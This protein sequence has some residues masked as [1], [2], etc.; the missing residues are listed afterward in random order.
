MELC[1]QQSVHASDANSDHIMR[2]II[3]AEKVTAWIV[4]LHQWS[5]SFILS[6]NTHALIL[7]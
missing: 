4:Y 2:D 6:T 5:E 1:K 3:N 7:S